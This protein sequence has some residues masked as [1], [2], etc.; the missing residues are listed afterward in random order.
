MVNNSSRSRPFPRG[1][2]GYAPSARQSDKWNCPNDH[3]RW[4]TQVT[5]EKQMPVFPWLRGH[6]GFNGPCHDQINRPLKK[7]Y[8][9]LRANRG[10][11]LPACPVSEGRISQE[12]PERCDHRPTVQASG[13]SRTP[14]DTGLD[15][16]RKVVLAFRHFPRSNSSCVAGDVGV[17]RP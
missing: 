13:L 4:H 2:P 6:T 5:P 16:A 9:D 1:I 17:I 14:R 10:R 11:R 12:R 3:G 7:R 8:R 15:A